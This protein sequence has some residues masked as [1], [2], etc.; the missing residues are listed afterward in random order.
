MKKI[1]A[2]LLVVIAVL[3]FTYSQIKPPLSEKERACINS[4]GTVRMSLCCKA[5]S[6]FPNLCLTGPCTCS[7]ENSH[8]V[9]ICD[10]PEGKCLDGDTCT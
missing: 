5:T 2:G 8:Q 1:I 9:K 3:V 4:G 7:P 10:C 6:N